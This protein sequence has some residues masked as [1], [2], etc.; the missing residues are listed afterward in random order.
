MSI[1]LPR[2]YEHTR[3]SQQVGNVEVSLNGLS[4]ELRASFSADAT[5]PIPENQPDT[6]VAIHMDRSVAMTLFARLRETFQ[7]MGWPLPPEA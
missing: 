4:V 6:S 2:P 7:T 3:Y 5:T 1:N